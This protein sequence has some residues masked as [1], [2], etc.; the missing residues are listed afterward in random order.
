MLVVI[1]SRKHDGKLHIV[2]CD[3]GQGDSIYV[4]LPNGADVLVD[5]GPQDA[6]LECLGT[7]MSPF[8]R[9]LDLVIATHPQKDHIHGLVNVLSR[10]SIGHFATTP[11]HSDIEEYGQIKKTIFQKQ[12]PSYFL[13][14]GESLVADEVTF[15]VLWPHHDWLSRQFGS[16]ADQIPKSGS[17]FDLNAPKSDVDP[18]VFSLYLH[19]QYKSFDLLLTGDGDIP[20]QEAL[21]AE[22]ISLPQSIEVLKVP[23]HGSKTG[24]TDTFIKYIAPHISVIQSGKNSYGHPDS[25]TVEKLSAFGK[26]LQ[27]VRTGDIEIIT[28]G[29]TVEI[30]E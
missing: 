23:H 5:G 17:F 24:M 10:Y 11:L 3:V 27:T 8:D 29:V 30:L 19:L 15:K 14:T 28:D 16:H 25:A 26:V 7:Y 2:F 13:T 9:S 21:L 22:G 12:I 20:V 18:N 4:K 1:I 6:V